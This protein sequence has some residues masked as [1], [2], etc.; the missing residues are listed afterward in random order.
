MIQVIAKLLIS[1]AVTQ[2][3]YA[4]MI[5]FYPESESLAK[6]LFQKTIIPTHDQWS[7]SGDSKFEQDLCRV[8]AKV[9]YADS[10]DKPASSLC[11]PKDQ[12]EDKSSKK[13]RKLSVPI[14]SVTSQETVQA[15]IVIVGLFARS[16]R[17]REILPFLSG[18]DIFGSEYYKARFFRVRL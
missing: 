5:L 14:P 11:T 6:R 7:N 4:E 18:Q 1:L 13:S 10:K 8:F 17:E 15:K 2:W 9:F 16:E 12:S 3:L